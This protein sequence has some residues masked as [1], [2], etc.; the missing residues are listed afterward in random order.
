MRINTIYFAVFSDQQ[1]AGVSGLPPLTVPLTSNLIVDVRP[2][3]PPAQA[4]LTENDDKFHPAATSPELLALPGPTL[5][6]FATAREKG[7]AAV[8][9]RPTRPGDDV[10]IIP[11]GT[12]SAVPSK[13]RNGEYLIHP[14]EASL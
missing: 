1:F 9:G 10:T 5:A 12:G 7:A 14:H 2:P 11:L 13:Y 6:A 8:H 3:R 4:K